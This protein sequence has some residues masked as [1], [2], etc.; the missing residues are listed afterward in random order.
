MKG[1]GIPGISS[2]SHH[3]TIDAPH[4]LASM[5][6]RTDS[7]HSMQNTNQDGTST[8]RS[9]PP[10]TRDGRPAQEISWI[11]LFIMDQKPATDTTMRGLISEE[12]NTS[13]QG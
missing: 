1:K 6:T 2:E 10:T 7:R 5:T 12:G 4:A 13:P 9:K 3:C 8:S 11:F